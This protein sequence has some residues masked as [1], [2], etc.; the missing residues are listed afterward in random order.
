MDFIRWGSRLM[1]AIQRRNTSVQIKC[2]TSLPRMFQIS[3]YLSTLQVHLRRMLISFVPRS[4]VH[5]YQAKR[6]GKKCLCV[7]LCGVCQSCLHGY[8]KL[9]PE[10][11]TQTATVYHQSSSQPPGMCGW[12]LC[13]IPYTV[14]QHAA[15]S[16]VTQNNHIA[17]VHYT[18]PWKLE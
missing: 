7:R 3:S 13:V 12:W 4:S 1:R 15:R 11:N 5:A 9:A 10:M 2:R 18:L 8:F 16:K 17:S 14:E 6:G